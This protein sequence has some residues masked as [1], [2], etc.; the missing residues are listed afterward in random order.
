MVV[1]TL[2]DFRFMK[3]ASTRRI[4]VFPNASSGVGVPVESRELPC[5]KMGQGTVTS[6][7]RGRFQGFSRFPGTIPDFRGFPDFRISKISQRFPLRIS[8]FLERRL[9]E[10]M[11]SQNPNR[12]SKIYR[13]TLINF[14][15]DN[16]LS[17]ISVFSAEAKRLLAFLAGCCHS[18]TLTFLSAV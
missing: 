16:L 14:K 17:C 11:T 10:E 1:Q 5:L 13:N 3:N 4:R 8:D 2:P 6:V 7:S 9:G 15:A 18:A 12:H